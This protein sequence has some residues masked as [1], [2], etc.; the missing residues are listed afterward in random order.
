M[1]Y[2]LMADA[3]V[4]V[5]LGFVAFVVVG[6]LLILVGLFAGWGW[7]R[8]PWFR[9]LHLLSIGIVVAEC[10]FHYQCPLTTWEHQLRELASENVEEPTFI[11]WLLHRVMFFDFDLDVLPY[12]Y[13]AFGGIVLGTFLLG[14]PR[15]PWRR[16]AAN[17]AQPVAAPVPSSAD[18]M[19][20]EPTTVEVQ[21]VMSR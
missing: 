2:S 20:R 14:P 18:L 15:L 12:Y 11:G 5:H 9:S 7:V 4:A 8:N 17:V 10:A 21:G 1:S 16:K 3:V 6:Q 19:L 13:A